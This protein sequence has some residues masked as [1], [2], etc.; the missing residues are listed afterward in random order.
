MLSNSEGLGEA[1][2]T[3]Q[4]A[5]KALQSSLDAGAA[6][7][8]SDLREYLSYGRS[9][10]GRCWRRVP[11]CAQCQQRRGLPGAGRRRAH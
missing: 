9:I 6:L 5:K 11:R 3:Y 1:F 4:D 10:V 2:A 8:D 7:M